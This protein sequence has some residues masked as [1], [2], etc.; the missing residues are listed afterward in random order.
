MDN[1]KT[2]V[3]DPAVKDINTHSNYQ[4]SWEQ[5]KTGRRVTHLTFTFAEKQLLTPEK[6]KRTTKPKEKTIYGVPMSEIDRLAR[7][8]ESYEQAAARIN[9]ERD[10]A[11]IP[12]QATKEVAKTPTQ[13]TK[14]PA[15]KEAAAQHI[16]DLKTALKT[17]TPAV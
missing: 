11:K 8:T 10:V 3:L 15:S 14:K 6:P 9:R 7:G 2:R 1:F 12:T 13:T 5:R 16:K 4:V 17:G